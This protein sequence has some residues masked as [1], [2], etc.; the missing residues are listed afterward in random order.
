MGRQ[1]ED[2]RG[3]GWG[4]IPKGGQNEPPPP[5]SPPPEP[6]ALDELPPPDP[7]QPKIGAAT[8]TPRKAMNSL[9]LSRDMFSFLVLRSD[10]RLDRGSSLTPGI[11]L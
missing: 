3:E 1:M 11:R 10:K 7:P 2:G 6:P 5:E 4:E 8:K 9:F